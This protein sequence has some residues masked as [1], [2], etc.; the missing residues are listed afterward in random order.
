[1]SIRFLHSLTFALLTSFFATGQSVI[2]LDA[3][4]GNEMDDLYAIVHAF[5]HPLE[6]PIRALTAAH[7]NNAQL[8]TDSLWHIYPTREINTVAISQQLNKELATAMGIKNVP[9]IIGADRM[10]GYAWGYY[11]G[12]PIPEAPAVSEIA[13]LAKAATPENKLH[14][15]CLGAVTNV[16]AALAREPALADRLKISF[17][18]M[19][20][21]ASRG[22]W[23]KNEF[24][25]RNDL[26]GLDLLLELEGL[27]LYIMPASTAGQLVFMRE[28]SQAKLEAINHPAASILR[29]RWDEVNAGES[30]IMWDLALIEALLHP[31]LARLEYRRVPPENGMRNIY[32]YTDINQE[33]MQA[34]FWKALEEME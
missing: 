30:W 31:S 6:L 14:V 24:N 27:E 16:A 4:T 34:N 8:L 17:L 12:A 3:D 11:P 5:N 10:L 2:V 9:V 22:I 29:D 26:N 19:R 25:A 13:R 23:D 1:M 20:Y 7:F 33:A 21:D 32:V 18:A 28:E 15:I